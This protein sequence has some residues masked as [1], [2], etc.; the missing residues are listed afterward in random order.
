MRIHI[1]CPSEAVSGSA[2]SLHQFGRAAATLGYDVRIAYL[3]DGDPLGPVPSAFRT[4]GV[5]HDQD[6]PDESSVA[7]LVPHT[8]VELLAHL[9]RVQ[10]LVWWLRLDAEDQA[11]EFALD[12]SGAIHLAQSEHARAF[13]ESRGVRAHLLGDYI[14]AAFIKRAEAL[15]PPE[16]LNT[17]LYNPD[18]SDLLTPRLIDASRDVLTWVPVTGLAPDDVAEIM[19]YSKV[20]VDFG[21]HAGRTRMPREA[22]ASGCCVVTGRR[23]ATGSAADLAVPDGFAFDERDPAAVTKILNRVALTLMEFG[24]ATQNFAAARRTVTGQEAA[25]RTDVEQ[26]LRVVGELAIAGDLRTTRA[27]G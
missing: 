13:L 12:V 24:E 8:A 27:G 19:A 10:K 1:V 9:T 15:A 5:R 11:V 22:L 2:E 20:F 25:F 23:G 21:R 18:P 3:P 14:R 6:I 4:Y 26:L 7:V 16:R 17:V